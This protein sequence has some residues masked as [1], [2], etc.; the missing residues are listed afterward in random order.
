MSLSLDASFIFLCFFLQAEEVAEDSLPTKL[1]PLDGALDAEGPIEKAVMVVEQK[2]PKPAGRGGSRYR[3]SCPAVQAKGPT[4]QGSEK[5][6]PFN[7]MKKFASC[8][9][10]GDG[11]ANVEYLDSGAI[12]ALQL[13]AEEFVT[14]LY[15]DAG[16]VASLSKRMTVSLVDLAAALYLRSPRAEKDRNDGRILN[17]EE[18]IQVIFGK[19]YEAAQG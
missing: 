19:F 16:T 11:A 9:I 8:F 5:G 7:T 1:G 17:G 13:A 10:K 15:H 2:V 14:A 12:Y 18:I 4:L 3:Q 6:L